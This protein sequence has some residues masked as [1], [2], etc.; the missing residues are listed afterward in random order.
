MGV[1]YL[2][3]MKLSEKQLRLLHIRQMR[4]WGKSPGYYK[5]KELQVMK[6]PRLTTIFSMILIF[7]GISLALYPTISNILAQKHASQAITEYNDEIKDMDEEKIDA[8][9]EAMQQYNE[10]LGN[11]VTQDAIGEQQTGTSHVDMLDIG[12]VIGYLTVPVINVN[13]P[14]YKGTSQDVLAKGVGYIPETSF[15]LGG[16]STHSVLTGHRGLPDAKLFTDM[17]KVQKKDQFYIHVLDE[18][19]AY[20]VDQIKVVDPEDTSDL[21]IVEGKDYV[22]LVTCT[23]YAVNT[24]RLL[25]RGHRVPY[26]GEEKAKTVSQVRPAAMAQR[27]VDVWPWFLFMMAGVAVTEGVIILLILIKRHHDKKKK[28]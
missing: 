1:S 9:K 28:G 20:E 27:V 2:P 21:D 8:V 24:H 23:P 17:D 3:Y 10:Q 26:T 5:G 18:V 22:T 11:A 19:L 12:D 7:A 4:G 14:I 13:L 16:E 25:V 6:K 15:P